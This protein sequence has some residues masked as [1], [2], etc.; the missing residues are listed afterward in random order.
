MFWF[1]FNNQKWWLSSQIKNV[2]ILRLSLWNVFYFYKK[3]YVVGFNFDGF[4]V[5]WFN[6]NSI[7]KKGRNQ[8]NV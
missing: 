1:N 3:F 6:T 2:K 4:C 7:I 8:I 5:L